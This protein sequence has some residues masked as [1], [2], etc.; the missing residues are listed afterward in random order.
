M[1]YYS[2]TRAISA[3]LPIDVYNHGRMR[4]DFTYI[5]D[6]AQAI[7]KLLPIP[8]PEA[9]AALGMA[10]AGMAPHLIYNVGNNV[11][12]ELGRFI[13]VIEAAV[14]R[15]AERRYL[16]MQP[17]DVIETSADVSRLATVTGYKPSTSIETGIGR[18]VEWYKEY[19]SDG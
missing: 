17:A 9:M 4:R 19:K 8:P 3:G 2:F 7:V 5:D 6:V 10:V 18:F 1:A 13:S 12:I 11:P 14:G 15:H 16:P